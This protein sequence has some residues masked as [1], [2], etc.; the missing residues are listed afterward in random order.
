MRLWTIH[1]SHLDT[2]RLVAQW[3]ECVTMMNVYKGLSNGIKSGGYYNHPQVLKLLK[4]HSND[5]QPAMLSLYKYMFEIL[6]ESR[7]RLFNFNE[8]IIE[9]FWNEF[10]LSKV[11]KNWKPLKI[12]YPG[13][14]KYEVALMKFKNSNW[15]I[16][17]PD[18]KI[19][20][21]FECVFE[22][23]W[24]KDS[25]FKSIEPIEKTKEEVLKIMKN[26]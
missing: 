5:Y 12:E 3:K 26:L 24:I 10:D 2:K 6:K 14:I 13:Q 17:W 16:S 18:V 11:Y 9:N 20:P 25:T 21:I 7:L 22:Y 8:D 1:P 4:M 19:N 23:D 15:K